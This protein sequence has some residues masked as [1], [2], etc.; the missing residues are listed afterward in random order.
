LTE[1]VARFDEDENVPNMLTKAVAG[2]S[3][4]LSSMTMNDNY[5]PHI[6]V[7]P[8]RLELEV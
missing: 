6:Q 3:L 1:A 5:K 7:C 4:Q 8:N 2:L